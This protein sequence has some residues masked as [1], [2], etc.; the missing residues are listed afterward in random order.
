MGF[1]IESGRHCAGTRLRSG[2][3]EAFLAEV[4]SGK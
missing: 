4:L 1:R 2:W 3:D